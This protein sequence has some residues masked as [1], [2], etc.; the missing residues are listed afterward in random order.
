MRALVLHDTTGPEALALEEIPAPDAPDGTVAVEVHAA[1][2]GFVDWLVTKG[3]YQIR[4]PLPFVPGIEVAGTL[5]GR[6][7]CATVAFGGLAETA[8]AP[9]FTVFDL[10]DAMTFAQGAAMVTNFQTAHLALARRG[11]LR[12][13]ETVLV[14]GAA[15]GVGLASIAVAKALG[16]AKVIAVVS[17]AERGETARAAGADVV[18]LPGDEWERADVVVDPVGG[19][20][21]K[22]ALRALNA[23][24]RLLVVGFA[25]GTIPQ[26]EVNRLLLRHTEVVGVNYGG[27]LAIDQ[28]FPQ[29]AWADLRRW[30]EEG[31]LPLP[32]I[33]E[34][35]LDAV[36]GILRALGE[37]RLGGKPVA[38]V[39]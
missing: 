9:A 6:R 25:S 5:D 3:E 38:L 15:G 17:T 22:P 16:A 18:H 33:S 14:L 1:G 10:P 34:H 35:P 24:G 39:R 4:P 8:I 32:G 31:R 36:P 20:A 23:E 13:G 29:A 21:F 19:D 27:M 11:R 2:L 7:V 26:L 30:F 28:A 12:E 37:R